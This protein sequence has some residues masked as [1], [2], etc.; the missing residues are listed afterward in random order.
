MVGPRPAPP[1]PPPPRAAPRGAA[2]EGGGGA[3]RGGAPPAP[4]GHQLREQRLGLHGEHG[5][6]DRGPLDEVEHGGRGGPAGQRSRH[7]RGSRI[8]A[9]PSVVRSPRWFTASNS[10]S[11]V[12]FSVSF[13]TTLPAHH[14]VS[15]KTLGLRSRTS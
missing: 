7:R 3:R 13:A 10:T 1:A 8:V 4:P 12:D 9:V 14:W 11:T 5:G 15:P 2:G 6:H